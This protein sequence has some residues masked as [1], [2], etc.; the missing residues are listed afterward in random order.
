MPSRGRV[1]ARFA[2]PERLVRAVRTV[3]ARGF[4]VRDVYTPYPLHE[5]DGPDGA[6]GLRRSRLGLVAF[7]GGL[8][9]CLSAIALQVGTAVV[10]WP[11]DVGGKPE[12]SAL[13]F[14]PITFELTILF[15]GLATA[16][17]FLL[18]SR[19]FPGARPKMP[20]PGV[21]DDAFV[22][23]AEGGYEEVLRALLLDCGADEVRD[24]PAR[25]RP[26]PKAPAALFVTFAAL[27][28]LAASTTGC[29]H[30]PASPGY[31]YMP[32][33]AYAVSYDAYAPNPN[34][35]DGQTLQRPVAGT[36]PRGFRP[37]HYAATAVDAERAGRELANPFTATPEDL[38]R[39]EAVFRT[40]C[41][42]CHGDRGLGD[43][44]IIPKFPAPPSYHS[45]R[46]LR[47]ADGQIFHTITYGTAL[48]P[49]YAAQITPEDRWR[50]VLF[51]RRLQALG[52]PDVKDQ[53]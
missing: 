36:I 45:D 25:R 19:L 27:T 34:T 43:G 8:A 50:A 18:G 46:L 51:V 23:V 44:P 26:R 35:R 3:R 4:A 14:L 42:V 6:M 49:S 40:F 12:N 31:T 32:D 53:E 5:L 21:T 33:M 41:R 29:R 24:L 52:P 2:E 16:A 39:G 37:L 10:D 9:G 13:A 48:M 28:A 20:L 15:S 30:D 1:V 17:A 38:A 11:I 22:L 7:L 47:M